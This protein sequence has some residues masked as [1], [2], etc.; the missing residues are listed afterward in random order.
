M[1]CSLPGSS[2]H[3]ISLVRILEWVAISFSRVSPQT[4]EW[5]LI[6]CTGKQILYHWATREAYSWQYMSVSVYIYIS[7]QIRQPLSHVWLFLTIRSAAHRLPCPSPSAGPCSNSC[8]LSQR[9]H[10]TISSSV[11]PFSSCPSPSIFPSI[12]IFPNKLAL[13]IRWPKY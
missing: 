1:G 9:C 8:L 5:I 6:S 11:V 3:G 7:D 12:R 2:V 4:Q 10:P 13:H